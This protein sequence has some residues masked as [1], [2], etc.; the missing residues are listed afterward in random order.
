MMGWGWTCGNYFTSHVTAF[1]IA[2]TATMIKPSMMRSRWWC[3]LFNFCIRYLF[4]IE[5]VY[6]FH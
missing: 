3:M 5:T 6:Y 1:H 2:I 4:R